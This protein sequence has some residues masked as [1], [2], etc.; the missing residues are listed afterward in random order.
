MFPSAATPAY[1][2]THAAIK[3]DALTVIVSAVI[4]PVTTCAAQSSVLTPAAFWRHDCR[5]YVFPRLSV[6]DKIEA[7]VVAIEIA[8]REYCPAVTPPMLVRTRV[9]AATELE[10]V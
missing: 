5:E 4:D 6:T 8:T 1:T 9:V 2:T 10:P 3:E 7:V